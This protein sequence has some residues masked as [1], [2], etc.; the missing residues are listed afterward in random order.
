M[1]G[2]SLD[3]TVDMKTCECEYCGGVQTL[4]AMD[5]EKKLNLFNRAN[6]LRLANE[7]DKA[8][9]VYESI[10]SEFPEEAE[11][12]WGLCLCKY[13][14]EY[15]D[16][17]TTGK[18][19]P[20]CHRTLYESIFDDSDFE[21]ACEYT[22]A[23]SKRIYREEAKEIDRL[24]RNVLEIVKNESPYDVFICY[25]ETDESGQRTK[26]SVLAQDIYDALT[27]KGYKVFFSRITLEDKLGQQYEPYIFAALSSAKVM[28][29][30]GTN[31]EYYNAVWVKNEWS[32]YLALMKKDKN[33][34]LIPCYADIDAYDMPQEFKNLQGQDMN[35]I[36]FIQDLVRGIGK[37][38]PLDSEKS[39]VQITQS[40]QQVQTII[41]SAN[42]ENLIKRGNMAV[43]DGEYDRARE[44]FEKVLDED[45][46]CAE[47]YWGLF[48][49]NQRCNAENAVN[50][51]NDNTALFNDKNIVKAVQFASDDYLLVLNKIFDQA[52]AISKE[53]MEAT[54]EK[55]YSHC[56]QYMAVEFV[57]NDVKELIKLV[58]DYKDLQSKAEEYYKA[59]EEKQ[60]KIEEEERIRKAKEEE[61]KH[62][63]EQR[64]KELNT[65]TKRKNDLELIKLEYL[66]YQKSKQVL[67][68]LL[69]SKSSVEEELRNK[70][71]EVESTVAVYNSLG[72]F[73]FKKR[74]EMAQSVV[75]M[76]DKVKALKEEL[77]SIESK[78]E[79]T[80]EQLSNCKVDLSADINEEVL[81][82][83]SELE[84]VSA[85]L[86]KLR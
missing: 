70:E 21:M 73:E 69:K 24:Q 20:T 5:N 55:A 26:D 42:T 66:K 68:E 7:F 61:K 15:V 8:A 36:G 57:E 9:T 25:K 64:E 84:K 75:Q 78:I 4:P 72:I 58:G 85:E 1:C 43:E 79:T 83:R 35:K 19:I 16:D 22:D 50:R 34:T 32:R 11:S 23:Y 18:K 67:D 74:K 59:A 49:V 46:E 40:V 51:L 63:R 47:A 60:R 53:K 12:Y 31:Y 28:L 44:H 71:K 38:I 41:Q 27:G 82:I 30:I 45:A 17:P 39:S 37:L 56:L 52:V 48:L 65:L 14:I 33:K 81:R 13:G 76:T 62:A 86:G 80:K 2:G 54:C 29:A 6:R 10:V 77:L 3:V